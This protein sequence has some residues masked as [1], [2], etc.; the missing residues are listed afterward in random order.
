MDQLTFYVVSFFG[1]VFLA[2]FGLLAY[3]NRRRIKNN[4]PTVIPPPTTT[5]NRFFRVW[6]IF[7]LLALVLIV[8]LVLTGSWVFGLLVAIC[9]IAAVAFRWAQVF[10]RILKK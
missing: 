4:E 3:A 1:T 7:L 6:T 2:L 5:S 8:G 9:L 10:A